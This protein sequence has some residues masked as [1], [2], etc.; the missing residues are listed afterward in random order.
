MSS[1]R[2]VPRTDGDE[3]VLDREQ[4]VAWAVSRVMIPTCN[5]AG[6]RRRPTSAGKCLTCHT[7][8]KLLVILHA[9][10]GDISRDNCIQCHMPKNVRSERWPLCV[11]GPSHPA[12]CLPESSAACRHAGIPG[13][14][15]YHT[16]AH[17]SGMPA[18]SADPG[19]GPLRMSESGLPGIP[20]KRFALL[21]KAP[22]NFPTIPKSRR[23]T[24]WSYC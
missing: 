15:I 16:E 20:A 3:P 12:N 2:L 19:A 10:T 11:D 4:R 17:K 13:R 1:K 24:G 6:R 18:G 14:L 8:P 23:H 5:C 22:E 7:V 21:D 9:K